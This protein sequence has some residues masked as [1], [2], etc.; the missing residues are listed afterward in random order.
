MARVWNAWQRPKHHPTE[1]PQNPEPFTS[2]G[3]V[4]SE[5]RSGTAQDW[6]ASKGDSEDDPYAGRRDS[7][8]ERVANP[9][10]FVHVAS[11]DDSPKE[12]DNETRR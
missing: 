3:S 8:N 1:S 4:G 6:T 5:N 9:P 11:P 10:G 7:T 2:N 12:R